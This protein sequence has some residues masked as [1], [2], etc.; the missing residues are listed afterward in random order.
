MYILN[1]FSVSYGSLKFTKVTAFLQKNNHVFGK[2]KSI[3]T[4]SNDTISL[5]DRHLIYA[6]DSI[7]DT[8]YTR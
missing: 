1:N 5:S 7:T 8:F 6:R 3:K 2:Y 4:V